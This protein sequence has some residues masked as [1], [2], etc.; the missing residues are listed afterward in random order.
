MMTSTLRPDQARIQQLAIVIGA[1]ARALHLR[2]D[3]FLRMQN[4]RAAKGTQSR[5]AVW[6]VCYYRLGMTQGEIGAMFRISD[7]GVAAGLARVLE[8]APDSL[9]M[10]QAMEA[11][12]AGATRAA[13]KHPLEDIAAERVLRIDAPDW[14]DTNPQTKARMGGAVT[15][16][17]VGQAS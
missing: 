1:V 13:R 14:R 16:A 2:A 11:A 12:E 4:P 7:A 17:K 3:E 9:L 8:L 6:W 10:C 5:Y 15:P